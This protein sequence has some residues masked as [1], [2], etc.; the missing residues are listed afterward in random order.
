VDYSLFN[1]C[2]NAGRVSYRVY[3]KPIRI[4]WHRKACNVYV[5][6]V[7][8]FVLETALMIFIFAQ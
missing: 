2:M 3:G 5:A 6:F 4:I 1:L 8:T 7:R